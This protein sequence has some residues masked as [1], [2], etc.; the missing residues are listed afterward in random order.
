MEEVRAKFYREMKKFICI[1]LQFRGVG[2]A[3]S[4]AQT[5]FPWM[6]NRNAADFSVIYKIFLYH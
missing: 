1:P 3:A 5:I 2:D 4:A 6:I